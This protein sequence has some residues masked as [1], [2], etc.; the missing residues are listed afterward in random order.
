MGILKHESKRW[1]LAL[2]V[3]R[4]EPTLEQHF[5]S[6]VAWD[7]WFSRAEPFRVIRVYCDNA[8]LYHAK[9][10]AQATQEWLKSG[11][12]EKMRELVQSM[13]IVVPPDRHGSMAKMSVQ[14]A[15]G[16]PGGLFPSL[17]AAFAWNHN[18]PEPASGLPLDLDIGLLAQA[19]ATV[20]LIAG[21][22]EESAGAGTDKEKPGAYSGDY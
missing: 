15:F 9:G 22:C 20:E 14:K 1:P 2:V 18:P 8:S 7:E 12:A 10:A 17:E 13:L 4:G 21:P 3:A 5:E 19:R 6:L 11:A 16:V